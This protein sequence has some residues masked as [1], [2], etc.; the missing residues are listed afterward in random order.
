MEGA[1]RLYADSR[2]SSFVEYIIIVGVVALL[3]IGAF[4]TFGSSIAGKLGRQG[5]RVAAMEGRVRSLETMR[6][7][8][9]AAETARAE[10]NLAA[11]SKDGWESDG[12]TARAGHDG[13]PASAAVSDSSLAFDPS[14]LVVALLLG[15]GTFLFYRWKKAR[16]A[17]TGPAGDATLDDLV[18]SAARWMS[19]V[20]AHLAGRLPWTPRD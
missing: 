12:E 11:R 10:K 1:V 4:A 15:A 18:A 20:R 5:E 3:G 7:A 16:R 8:E 6:P 13:S 9:A 19:T 17:T 2:G 14:A